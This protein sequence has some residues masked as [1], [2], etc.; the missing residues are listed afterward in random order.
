MIE[1]EKKGNTL[2]SQFYQREG[3][4]IEG[5]K[6]EVLDVQP[7]FY[8]TDVPAI[9]AAGWGLKPDD[10]K[11]NILGLA[12]L[13][14]RVLSFDAPHGIDSGVLEERPEDLPDA[15]L[16]KTAAL[17]KTLELKNLS[18]VDGVGHSEA[19]IY[20]V[21]AA[22]LY[23]EKFRNLVL[24]N[25][26]GTIGKDNLFR[27][28]K[29][30]SKDLL[31][32]TIEGIIKGRPANLR[33]YW[34]TVKYMVSNPVRSAKETLALSNTQVLDELEELKNLGIG[35]SIV[36]STEDAVLPIEKAMENVS[37][38]HVTGYYSIKGHHDDVFL[39]PEIRTK[40][41]DQALD[42][43]EKRKGK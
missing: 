4:E 14:R 1:N 17:I 34:N 27:L 40:L 8:K 2:E 25:P 39:D 9:L 35:V 16:R 12:K 30:F 42:S 20:L 41:A 11:E 6:L 21:L 7:D 29:S 15:E 31:R 28:T 22:I 23:P 38:D 3:F 43:L 32:Q 19:G 24:F 33:A 37:K 36:H 13:G 26:S 18:R 5:K 10:Y